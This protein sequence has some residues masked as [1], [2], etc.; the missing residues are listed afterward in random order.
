M[1]RRLPPVTGR[2]MVRAL[3][4]AS[5]ITVRISGSH[6]RLVHLGD[7]SRAATVPVHGSK[8]LKR[9]TLQSILRQARIT[10]DELADLL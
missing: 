8:T 1:S 7:A 10:A 4:K 9:G 6:H 3:E 2:D 5:F